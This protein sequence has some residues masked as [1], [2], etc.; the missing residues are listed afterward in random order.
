M[1][2]KTI[3]IVLASVAVV[4]AGT[5]VIVVATRSHDMAPTAD[6]RVVAAKDIVALAADPQMRFV[7]QGAHVDNAELAARL[8]LVPDDVIVALSGIPILQAHDVQRVIAMNGTE[9]FAEIVHA[10]STSI[11]RWK[12][13]GELREARRAAQGSGSIALALPSIPSAPP[14]SDALLDTITRIDDSHFTVPLGTMEAIFAD[15]AKFTT[16]IRIVP[17]TV[18]GVP[19]GL[20]LYG[21]HPGSIPGRLGMMNGDT[22]RLINGMD[23][24]TPTNALDTYSKLRH[25][26]R[27]ELLIIR[28][29]QPS[30]IVITVN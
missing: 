1:T 19:D 24:S 29:G 7:A 4:L 26:T 23:L 16:S 5:S 8:G 10:G 28:R 14:V 20:K 18:N 3:A 22:L 25:A 12:L 30:T 6:A 15:P 9:V 2:G 11:V 27:L 21:I 17:A 13:T